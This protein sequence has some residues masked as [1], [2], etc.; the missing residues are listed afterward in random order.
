MAATPDQS[1]EF[2]RGVSPSNRQLKVLCED[3]SGTYVP[4]FV[5][6]WRDGRWHYLNSVKGAPRKGKAGIWARIPV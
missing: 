4:S 5:C 3:A 2:H 6:I 1:S